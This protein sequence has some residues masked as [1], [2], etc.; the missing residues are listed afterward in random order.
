MAEFKF[1]GENSLRRF[2]AYPKASGQAKF[3]M[4]VVP[5]NALVGKI[6]RSP[7]A[8]ARIKRLDTRKAEALPGV[9]AVIT[10][11]DEETKKLALM[12]TIDQFWVEVVRDL[13]PVFNDRA[14]WE[15]E[16][17]GV[18]LAAINDEIAEEALKLIDVEWE[19]LPFV[20]DASEAMKPGAV[21]LHP[22]YD[23]EP[24]TGLDPSKNQMFYKE[25]S[26]GD[27]EKGFAEAD[28]SIEFTV[29]QPQIAHAGIERWGVIASWYGDYLTL[30][31]NTQRPDETGHMI[32]RWLRIDS[33]SVKVDQRDM[34][35]GG[36]Y[37]NKNIGGRR[38]Q[39]VAAM[40][41]R[42]TGKPVKILYS[43][44]EDF[45]SGDCSSVNNIK[46]GYKNDGTIT[47][48][49]IDTLFNAGQDPGGMGL[50]YGIM[51]GSNFLRE[52]TRASVFHKATYVYTNRRP[53]WWIRDQQNGCAYNK[54]Q[55]MDRV[56]DA[57]GMDPTEIYLKNLKP[58]EAERSL[59]ECTKTGK[60]AMGWDKK[61]HKPG[62]KTLPN[63]KKHGIGHYAS[64]EWNSGARS[65]VGLKIAND[66]SV[67]IVGARTN[68]GCTEQTTYAMIVAEELGA[69]V[70]DVYMSLHG[71]DVGI[72][73]CSPGGSFGLSANSKSLKEAASIMKGKLIDR[74]AQKLAV[75]ADEL[76]VKDSRIYVKA[77]PAKSLAFSEVLDPNNE[78]LWVNAQ[79]RTDN[80]NFHCQQAHFAEVEVNTETGEV[81]VTN[82]A[83]TNDVGKCIRPATVE[84][85]QYGAFI[86]AIGRFLTEEEIIDRE[87]G[88]RL[89]PNFLDYKVPTTL[90]VPR[91]SGIKTFIKEIGKEGGAWGI[92]G[93]GEDCAVTGTPLLLNALYNAIGVRIEPPVTPDK[94]L[95]ALGKT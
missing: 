19:I 94:V 84:A 54:G 34:Y 50:W 43:R 86:Q 58:K 95:K 18:A 55:V 80:S 68:V 56:A 83:L 57:L 82:I 11:K 31:A 35:V 24:I 73:M 81:E 70:D 62:K 93:V 52:D 67:L 64:H 41:A 77:D 51:L 39:I 92:C 28:H 88:V 16:E 59:R 17:V 37:G 74:A 5:K 2:D 69:L 72:Q 79:T 8:H 71:S 22:E 61:W 6:L 47:A 89:N 66:G 20:L 21:L 44:K 75:S 15:G 48:V 87:T 4:D 13:V 76:D 49:D 23:P 26:Q 90:E 65:Q 29:K 45:S 63:G 40:L 60:E 36:S 33:S 78:T 1:I 3:C 25:L 32:S 42:K 85:Q 38:F 30:R 91:I 14:G 46:V 12:G 53:V 7:Y 9:E 27:I 10:Y